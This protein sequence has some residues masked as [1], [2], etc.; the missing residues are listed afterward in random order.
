MK[1]CGFE[2]D[3]CF[4]FTL[5]PSRGLGGQWAPPLPPPPPPYW[6]RGDAAVRRG[7]RVTVKTKVGLRNWRKGKER[8]GMGMGMV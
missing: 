3:A 1:V 2:G 4:G 5:L 7:S 6:G 8:K